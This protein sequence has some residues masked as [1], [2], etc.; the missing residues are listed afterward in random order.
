MKVWLTLNERH[1]FRVLRRIL[2]PKRN[3]NVT[4]T[5]IKLHDEELHMLCPVSMLIRCRRTNCVRHLV[6]V[7]K[8]R[9][10]HKFLSKRHLEDV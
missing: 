8:D 6:H 7:S 4:G 10:V 3:V 1:K 9:D 5:W 2:G